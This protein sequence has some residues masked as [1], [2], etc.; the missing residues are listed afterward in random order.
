MKVLADPALQARSP[1]PRHIHAHCLISFMPSHMPL[2]FARH[3]QLPIVN[4]FVDLP[5]TAA[6]RRP[7]PSHLLRRKSPRCQRTKYCSPTLQKRSAEHYPKDTHQP[8]VCPDRYGLDYGGYCV[9]SDFYGDW[10]LPLLMA[11]I[12]ILWTVNRR[13]SFLVPQRNTFTGN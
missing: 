2:V 9:Y 3:V 13:L 4:Q 1:E 6:Q 5:Y 10:H 12:T 8:Y 7:T 11:S